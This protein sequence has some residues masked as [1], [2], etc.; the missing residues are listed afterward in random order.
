MTL[1]EAHGKNVRITLNDGSVFEGLAYDYTSA[2]DN[3]PDPESITIDHT[4]LFVDE[5]KSIDLI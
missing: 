4:E 5:I 3:E 2:L 1:K